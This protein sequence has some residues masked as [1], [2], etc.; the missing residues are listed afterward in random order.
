[1]PE[2]AFRGE[3]DERY[4]EG[5]FDLALQQVKILGRRRGKT[6]CMLFSAESWRNRSILALECSGP[7][8]SYPCGSSMTSRSPAPFCFAGGNELVDNHLAAIDKIS[9]LGFPDGQHIR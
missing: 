6:T 7:W 3:Y 4:A 5:L 1:M 9:I 8:P 2:K